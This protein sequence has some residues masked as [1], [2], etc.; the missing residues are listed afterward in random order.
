MRFI[1]LL[2]LCLPLSYGQAPSRLPLFGGFQPNAG[3]FP[4]AVRFVRPSQDNFNFFYLTR[5][6]FCLFNGVRVQIA[7]IDAKA[8]PVGESPTAAVYNFYRGHDPSTWSTGV[9]LF[10]TVRLDNVY[11]NINAAFTTAPAGRG[12]IVF[13][14]APGANPEL[15]R[16]R[17]LNTG[18]TP[19]EGPDGIWFAGSGIAGVFNVTAKAT[20]IDAETRLPINAQLAIESPDTLSVQIPDLNPALAA[21][22]EI[23][24]PDYDNI[25]TRPPGRFLTGSITVPSFGEDGTILAGNGSADALVARVDEQ[26]NPVWVTVLSGLDFERTNLA[27][28]TVD[29]LVVSGATWSGDFP[30]TADGPYQVPGS[31]SGDMFLALLDPSSG[32]LRNATYAG[33]P[34]MVWLEQLVVEPGGDA[35]VSGAYTVASTETR[36]FVLRWRPSQNRFVFWVPFDSPVTT[37]T[38]DASSNLYFAAA[39]LG[40]ATLGL[41]SAPILAG[42][43]DLDGKTVGSV[44]RLNVPPGLHAIPV[45]LLPADGGDF[46]IAYH[47]SYPW[48]QVSSSQTAVY[49]GRITPLSGRILVNRRI[50][51]QGRF[52]DFA[53]TPSGNLKVLVEN[54]AL[55]ERTTPDAQLVAGCP[56]TS[57]FAILSPAGELL[58]AT[59]VPNLG[60]D[61][62]Q[63]NESGGPPEPAVACFSGTAGRV[64]GP[65]AAP[66]EMI[67]LNGSGFGPSRPILA[68]PL[69]NGRYPVTVAGYRVRI[70]GIDAP[71]FSIGRGLITVQVP[72]ETAWPFPSDLQVEVFD[73]DTLLHSIP[74][75][76]IS[77]RFGLFDTGQR[78]ASFNAP[79]LAALNEDGTMNGPENPAPAGSTL[80][81]FGSGA[82]VLSPPLNTGELS[83]PVPLSETSLLRACAGCEVLSVTSAP[84]LSTAVV[85]VKIRI[86]EDTPGSGVRAHAIGVAISETRR[87]LAV[88]PRS[89]VVFIK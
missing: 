26:G 73:N 86:T 64:Q 25:E 56:D 21:E 40:A 5:D 17:V 84:V 29:G 3:Q 72:Y 36:G 76:V 79:I 6:A 35:A 53:Q 66:G 23:T 38:F 48:S 9:H 41:P 67:T 4:P 82:G 33:V 74:L 28:E 50:A 43:L 81:L 44:V 49:V 83:P 7:G 22:V 18:T 78:D 63:Q 15:I 24:F 14:L 37:L 89:G 61:F 11:P 54:A 42:V 31:S 19:S 59:Y 80:M 69:A 77:Y 16:L 46:W 20:Q 13:S 1:I 47:L 55:N 2:T 70:G 39:T 58:Y 85:Q 27:A 88:V 60:F 45:Q 75:V 51:D 65:M 8:E 68:T 52:V 30:V 57:Y 71:I 34:G 62:A 10:A 32:R 12:K 87:G